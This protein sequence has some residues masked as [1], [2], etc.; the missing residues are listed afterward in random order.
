MQNGS[1]KTAS[2]ADASGG[3]RYVI[4]TPAWNEAAFIEL[5]LKSMVVQTVPPIKWM[6]VSDG[7][8]DGTDEIVKKYADQYEWIELL[9]MP[10]RSERHFAGKVQ[11]FNAGYERVRPLSY[12]VIGN[13]DADISFPPGLFEFLLAK[14]AQYPLLGVAGTEYTEDTP[15]TNNYNIVN[16]EDVTGHCQ[17][18]RRECFEGIGGYVPIKDGGIDSVAVITARMEGWMT[19]TFSEQSCV[20]HRRVGGGQGSHF[21]AAYRAGKKDYYGGTHPLWAFLRSF[22]HINNKPYVLGSVLLFAGY[23]SGVLR[24]AELPISARLVA[25]RRNEQMQ[26]LKTMFRKWFPFRGT[27]TNPDPPQVGS[28]HSQAKANLE[29]RKRS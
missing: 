23:L 27:A 14:F 20:H 1:A 19:R 7:S 3:L 10:E 5:T 9:R 17:L 12:D 2:S 4:I 28:V 26:R 21:A 13:V 22:Y 8:T 18:F 15:V 29:Q 16:I 24:S 6:I 11:A 25:F